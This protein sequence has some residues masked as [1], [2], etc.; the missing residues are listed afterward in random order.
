MREKGQA[1]T[2]RKNERKGREPTS[3]DRVSNSD[4]SKV[5]D[6]R[7]VSCFNELNEREG[8]KRRV[9]LNEQSLKRGKEVC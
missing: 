3:I 6:E 4:S 7:T 9:R 5:D 1:N 8:R 2:R